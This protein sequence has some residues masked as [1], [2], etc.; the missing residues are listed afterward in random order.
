MTT[1]KETFE[2]VKRA[3]EKMTEKRIEAF[4]GSLQGNLPSVNGAIQWQ[5]LRGKE[6]SATTIDNWLRRAQDAGRLD[7]VSL[8]RAAFEVW[9]RLHA[10]GAKITHQEDCQIIPVPEIESKI[11][12]AI[13][14]KFAQGK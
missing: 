4:I 6:Y 14:R 12:R 13:E 8:N 2:D 11:A 3:A 10:V 7:G 1:K 5:D 9:K